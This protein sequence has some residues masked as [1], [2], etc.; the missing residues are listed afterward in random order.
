SDEYANRR[1][2]YMNVEINQ[3][4]DQIRQRPTNQRW[5]IPVLLSDCKVPDIDIG[6]GQTL[7]SFHWVELFENWDSGIQRI[8]NVLQPVSE[9]LELPLGESSLVETVSKPSDEHNVGRE[10]NDLGNIV[11]T[12]EPSQTFPL[13]REGGQK[14]IASK[15]S[16]L[17][18][19]L[20]S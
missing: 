4:I 2:T 11:S 8:L 9:R 12:E 14:R 10:L 19:S 16:Q 5:F 13:L 17:I 6:A 7:G 15:T 18:T 1:T 3:A 20:I